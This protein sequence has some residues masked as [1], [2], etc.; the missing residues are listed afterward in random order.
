MRILLAASASYVPPRG[1]ATR[2]NLA[3]LDDLSRRGH[4][5]RVVAAVLADES[6]KLRQ[7]RDEDIRQEFV[8]GDSLPGVEK[9]RRGSMAVYSVA[10]PIRRATILREQI[11]EFDPGFVLISSED[12][13]QLLLREAVRALPGR[14]VY[15]A[16]TPQFFPFGPESW[17]P[18]AHGTGLVQACAAVI[19]IGRHMA[20]YIKRHAG[21]EATVIH[22]PVYDGGPRR[23][24]SFESGLVTMINPSAVKGISIF[25]ELATRFPG[26]SFAALPGWGTTSSDLRALQALPNVRL[27][28]NVK[29]IG[30]VFGQTRVLLMPSLWYE[31]FGMTVVEAMLH[32]IPA[33]A[34]DSGGLAEAK[35]GTRFLLPVRPVEKYK[36][37]FDE[38][39]LPQFDAPPQPIEAWEDALRTLLSDRELFEEE[40][41]IAQTAAARFVKSLRPEAMEEFLRELSGSKGKPEETAVAGLSVEKRELLLQRLR[42][43]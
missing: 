38:R 24:G 12:V 40:G 33:L 11:R 39:G 37:I 42:Q 32:G 28:P 1:G 22:P 4:D 10:N 29:Q 23:R 14:V 7:M 3:W 25:I 43:R 13:G 31:G 8:S 36:K 16:H 27:L 19:A 9:S 18:D 30:T 41:R 21:C 20:D 35:L 5:C 2:A 15:L 34:S 26:L 17:S 6:E